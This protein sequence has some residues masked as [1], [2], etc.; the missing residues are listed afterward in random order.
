MLQLPVIHVGVF[1]GSNYDVLVIHNND[2]WR[3]HSASVT[4][5]DTLRENVFDLALLEPVSLTQGSQ[6]AT[7]SVNL[8]A[9]DGRLY[10][11]GDDLA[12]DAARAGVLRRRC[13]HQARMLRID[14][15]FS[16]CGGVDIA[17]VKMLCDRSA[18]AAD[19]GDPMMALDLF[20]QARSALHAAENAVS[21]YREIRDFIESAR[22]NL[23]RINI[24]FLNA[25][26]RPNPASAEGGPSLKVL[27]DRA[28]TQM[29]NFCLNENN[30]RAG[31]LDVTAA[32][33]L[34][35]EI[36]NL[37]AD[38]LSYQPS[39]VAKGSIAV[40]D[41]SLDG[42]QV[43]DPEL[44]ALAERLRWMFDDVEQLTALP[45]G[46]WVDTTGEP[47]GLD[48]RDMV[49]IHL[50]G[51]SPV[52]QARYCES[53]SLVPG[54]PP[55]KTVNSLRQFVEDGGGL[56]LSGL[57]TCLAA[58]FGLEVSRPNY[59]YWGTILVPGHDPSTYTPATAPAVKSLGLKPMVQ[60]HPLFSGLPA[61]G[62]KT[63]SFSNKGE[64]V[65][66]A[67][68]QRPEWPKKGRVLAGYWA[69][70]VSIPD[71]Y[72]AVVEYKM[73][74]GGKVI[75]LGGAFDPRLGNGQARSG[76]HY[77]RLIRNVVA[78]CSSRE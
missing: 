78:Y 19:D 40:I 68:W 22:S 23:D 21:E 71:N 20:K 74:N 27:Q 13:D 37:K 63:I 50:G 75:L 49:W 15:E 11:A 61:G 35:R 12:V 28:W 53:A 69:D 56:V 36:E 31:I 17:A 65:T 14:C 24:W 29:R 32:Y 1:S 33:V 48:D 9:G 3:S 10:L 45:K 62:F 51:R 30:F 46:Q 70:G 73:D 18:Q 42:D 58:T 4:L 38:V 76:E 41:L 64:L 47:A 6:G 72:A 44:R 7:F 57:S 34:N 77:D 5:S 8:K 66:E 2:P 43:G 39:N 16:E 26:F 25:P 67:L 60:D 59:C 54:I 55:T 52:V